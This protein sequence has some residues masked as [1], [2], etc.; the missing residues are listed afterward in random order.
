MWFIVVCTLVDEYSLLL[1]SLTFFRIVSAFCI[2]GDFAKDF[3]IQA[4]HLHNV[5]RALSSLQDA[6][7][8]FITSN[9]ILMSICSI[10]SKYSLL[11]YFAH[12][13]TKPIKFIP[14]LVQSALLG[15]FWRLTSLN[16]YGNMA[17]WG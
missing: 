9:F 16:Q 5:G 2:L 11:L 10:H 12:I 17:L 13:L 3:D 6:M 14:F 15:W 1:F 4:A 7:H 8:L